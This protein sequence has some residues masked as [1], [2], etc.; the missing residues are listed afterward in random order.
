MI[1][2]LSIGKGPKASYRAP[3]MSCA[4]ALLFV[5]FIL[6][7]TYTHPPIP[8]LITFFF[9]DLHA[10]PT[11]AP[12]FHY[13]AFTS[14]NLNRVTVV[15]FS[16]IANSELVANFSSAHLLAFLLL[17]CL[18][19]FLFIGVLLVLQLMRGT[20]MVKLP[21]VAISFPWAHFVSAS[22]QQCRRNS[23]GQRL[24][25]ILCGRARLHAWGAATKEVEA[26]WKWAT[27]CLFVIYLKLVA[28]PR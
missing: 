17:L 3:T 19:S 25:V 9:Q 2:I 24:Y 13:S 4:S 21:G 11:T 26:G 20:R 14:H 16:S 18:Q 8:T 22:A 6:V 27:L 5:S 7:P 1:E 12:K 28:E 23:Y 15:M 10:V